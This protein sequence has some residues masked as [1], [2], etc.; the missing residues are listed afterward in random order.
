[1]SIRKDAQIDYMA[2]LL[3]C[4]RQKNAIRGKEIAIIFQEA[5]AYRTQL[6]IGD[7]IKEVLIIHKT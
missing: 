7:Q 2:Q 3:A 5:L 6:C 4:T 1:M